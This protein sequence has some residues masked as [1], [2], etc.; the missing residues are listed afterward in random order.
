MIDKTKQYW[1]GDGPDDIDEYLRLYTREKALEVKPV[2]CRKCEGDVFRVLLDPDEG[3]IQ[4]ICP[5]CGTEKLLLDS[6]EYWEDAQPEKWECPVCGGNDTCSVRV[7][8]SRGGSGSVRWVTIG[9]R[10]TV[11]GTLGSPL[12]WEINYEPTDEMEKEI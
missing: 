9:T 12:D 10:C 2:I 8:L 6:G 1:T 11:C 5:N 4:V 7:G 3:V